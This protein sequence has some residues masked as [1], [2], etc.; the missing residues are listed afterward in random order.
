MNDATRPLE[1]TAWVNPGG[2]WL[3]QL[4]PLP[5]E[6]VVEL[7]VVPPLPPPPSG[8]D[9]PCPPAPAPVSVVLQDLQPP[10]AATP[11][12]A[13]AAA[14]VVTRTPK[15]VENDVSWDAPPWVEVLAGARRPGRRR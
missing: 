15:S 6:L 11:P 5:L 8:S 13:R 4:P 7:D 3:L 2:R 10:V 14:T 9:P 1:T 12:R